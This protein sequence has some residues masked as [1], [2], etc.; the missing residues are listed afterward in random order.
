MARETNERVENYWAG[1]LAQS[2]LFRNML[3]AT[4]V[5]L[6]DRSQHRDPPDALFEVSYRDG[7][8]KKLW[9][10]ISGAWRSPRGAQEVFEVVEGKRPAPSGPHGV[11]VEPDA[12]TADSVI[13][14]ILTKLGKDTYRELISDHGPGHLHIFLSSDHYPLFGKSTLRCISARLPVEQLQDRA[15]F[16]SISLGYHGQLYSLWP[17]AIC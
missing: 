10:E 11:M 13:Q 5:E 6:I 2:E 4:N 15:M 1:Q 12:R 7:E 14:A 16:R 17:M 9:C 3:G 8:P